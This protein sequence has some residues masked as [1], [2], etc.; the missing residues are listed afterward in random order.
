MPITSNENE[1]L[2]IIQGQLIR[3]PDY[4]RSLS[5]NE[6][7]RPPPLECA[8]S[9][10]QSINTDAVQ[11]G[12]DFAFEDFDFDEVADTIL[13]EDLPHPFQSDFDDLLNGLKSPTQQSHHLQHQ[14]IFDSPQHNP[15]WSLHN[16]TDDNSRGAAELFPDFA[17]SNVDPV[18]SNCQPLN[19]RQAI[20]NALSNNGYSDIAF[21][22]SY[23]NHGVPPS[24]VPQVPSTLNHIEIGDCTYGLDVSTDLQVTGQGKRSALPIR[25][26]SNR[27]KTGCTT[28]RSRASSLNENKQSTSLMRV[29]SGHKKGIRGG[30][31][32]LAKA[33]TI[34]QKRLAKT[35][36]ISC[37]SKRVTVRILQ[38]QCL[39]LPL[40]D[41]V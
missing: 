10:N 37:K 14:F 35:M 17:Q 19:A 13:G 6:A 26:R 27:S 25:T 32:P 24:D 20:P 28:R 30:Q 8:F 12:M 38:E 1:D 34:H 4:P 39:S 22:S 36:C 18:E 7:A 9:S 41:S 11:N 21:H 5:I 40:T 29:G 15:D 16:A 2:E 31:L 3:S 23:V 33:K